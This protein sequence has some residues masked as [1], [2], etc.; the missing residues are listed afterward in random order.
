MFASTLL[1][2][3]S[4]N[5]RDLPWRHTRDPYAIW[6]SE[7][8]L[9]QTRISQGLDYW[10]RFVLR[11]PN[12]EALAGATEDEV[13]REW[14]G[15]GYYTRARN[16]LKTAKEVSRLGHF[17]CTYESLLK[18]KGIGPY[19]AAAIASMAFDEDVAVVDGNVYRVLARH[20]GVSTPINSTE[21]AKEF[22]LLANR[23]LPKGRSAMF[24]QAMMD[25]GAT[26]CTPQSPRCN[27]CPLA[28]TCFALREDKV[29]VLPVKERKLVV[30]E[31][32]M[33]YIYIRC[34]GKV[35]LHRRS[36]GDIWQGL[37]EPYLCPP[38][39][40]PQ[41]LGA[42]LHLLQRGV[43]HQLTHRLVVCDFFL[44][45]PDSTPKLPDDFLWV[46]EEALDDYAKPRLVEKLFE[47]VNQ[48]GQT[49]GIQ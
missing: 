9:Q 20:F 23:L 12:V 44:C 40:L 33:A 14:Q 16:L 6:L 42:P 21:G 27:D 34:H 32:L 43:R 47:A 10:S 46:D 2:W 24:N 4:Q 15:L 49:R 18:L 29:G 45:L 11:W 28:E 26:L 38:E 5:G 36:E 48:S 39:E 7:V 37:W 22:R 13:L 41:D 17:P 8:I 31:R 25:F 35:A 19:T 1:H 3:F 30:K